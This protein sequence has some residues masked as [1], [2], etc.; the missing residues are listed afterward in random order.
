[1]FRR[2]E[3]RIKA[4]ADQLFNDIKELRNT[5]PAPHL[6]AHCQ[7]CEKVDFTENMVKLNPVHYFNA[8]GYTQDSLVTGA[9]YKKG[10]CIHLNPE[11]RGKFYVHKECSK[12]KFC[13]CVCGLVKVRED[14]EDESN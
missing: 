10:E 11:D 4:I 13:D 6:T 1:M 7:E 5:P 14:D 8:L 2:K 9:F 3:D 12:V